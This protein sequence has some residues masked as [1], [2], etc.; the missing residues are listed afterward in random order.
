MALQVSHSLDPVSRQV[1]VAA[2]GRLTTL[3]HVP[4]PTTIGVRLQGEPEAL[5]AL[6]VLVVTHARRWHPAWA[7]VLAM[8]AG[9]ALL[10]LQARDLALLPWRQGWAALQRHYRRLPRWAPA[11]AMAGLAAVALWGPNSAVRAAALLA[12]GALT[13]LDVELALYGALAALFAAPLNVA[14]GRWQFSIAVS[15]PLLAALAQ[16]WSC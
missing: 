14:L 10:G 3:V 16:G 15:W 7:S 1:T 11:A 2:D 4:Q 9:L 8:L 13:L 12:Y 5:D 6:D